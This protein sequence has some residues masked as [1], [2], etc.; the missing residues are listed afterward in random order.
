[1]NK[2]LVV[3]NWK[4]N[5]TLQEAVLLVEELNIANFD[6]ETVLCVPFTHIAELNKI[7]KPNIKIG[8]QNLTTYKNGAYT[9]EI[10]GEILK[11]IGAE[12]VIIGH[13]ERRMYYNETNENVNTKIKR[14]LENN[15]TPIIC[16]G[17]SLELRKEN[18]YLFFIETQVKEA[19]ENIFESDFSKCML[20]YEPIWAIGTGETA[21]PTQAQEVHEFVRNILANLYNKDLAEKCTI[22]YGGSVKPNNASS[23]F[24]QHD[25]D[26]AL[27]GGASLNANNFVQIINA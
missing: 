12:Y 4:M 22:L 3:G 9:G 15:I 13:S 17:E 8:A 16:F 20:A 10:S 19:F 27:V 25:I 1:M 26:G 7:A 21:T 5:T 2:R 24:C 6:A 11:S 14:A 18:K 23:L